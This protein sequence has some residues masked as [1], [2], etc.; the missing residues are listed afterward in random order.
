MTY[1]FIDYGLG[2]L[3]RVLEIVGKRS[4]ACDCVRF[5]RRETSISLIR[6]LMLTCC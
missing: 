1:D 5:E 2:L 6:N 4:E 3:G